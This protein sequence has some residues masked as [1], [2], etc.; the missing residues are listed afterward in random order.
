[1]LIDV[2]SRNW[3]GPV[4]AHIGDTKR[5]GT[6]ASLEGRGRQAFAGAAQKLR[7][8]VRPSEG[9]IPGRILAWRRAISPR[10]LR[11]SYTYRRD[12]GNCRTVTCFAVAGGTRLQTRLPC[13]PA[14]NPA[15]VADFQDREPIAFSS[16]K[17]ALA[18]AA[19]HPDVRDRY[20]RAILS[21]L[22]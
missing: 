20:R 12:K 11:Q 10:L 14:M 4:S 18:G 9:N 16:W 22:R 17:A 6:T 8:I 3:G 7:R 19:L 1:M 15:A 13:S 5:A 2:A 21:L